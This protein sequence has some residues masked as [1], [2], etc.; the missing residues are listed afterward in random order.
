MS[1]L[2]DIHYHYPI[3]DLA[4][5]HNVAGAKDVLAGAEISRVVLSPPV[6]LTDEP[7]SPEYCRQW[8]RQ[9]V[10]IRHATHG[11]CDAYY[12]LPLPD[13]SAA[14]EE[15]QRLTYAGR[16]KFYFLTRYRE[17]YISDASF[18]PVLSVLNDLGAVLLLHPCSLP[19]SRP[20][21]P[22]LLDFPHDT[23]Q[24]IIHMGEAHFFE[25]YS[26]LDVILCHGGGTMLTLADRV[27][28]WDGK[29]Y[30]GDSD[31]LGFLS[32]FYVDTALAGTDYLLT[33]MIRLFPQDHILYGS[34]SEKAPKKSIR[35][36]QRTIASF[37]GP[38]SAAVFAEN[39][40]VLFG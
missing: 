1:E 28:L 9:A 3:C 31:F 6:S 16:P 19:G 29:L 39:A 18:S 36:Q 24:A 22:P 34:D 32:N 37:F 40:K 2:F 10:Q 20:L 5:K 26:Q 27:R 21:P 38:R 33:G 25:A 4:G 13:V 23:A 30:V 15:L 8:N 14:L 35:F 12:L 11:T 7:Y 17:K